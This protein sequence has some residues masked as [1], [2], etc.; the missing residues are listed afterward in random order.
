MLV[1]VLLS[2]TACHKNLN[3]ASSIR[4]GDPVGDKQLLFGF[5]PPEENAWAWTAKQFAFFLG[6]PPLSDRNGAELLVRIY[7]PEERLK[8]TGPVTLSADA[9]CWTLAPATYAVGGEQL[10]KRLIPSEA[11]MTNILPIHFE[12]N[13]IAPPSIADNRELGVVVTEARLNPIGGKQR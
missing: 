6:T 9:D 4:V 13:K 8:E 3:P 11:L 1:G 10:Y 12:V 2:V 5:Y 7:L